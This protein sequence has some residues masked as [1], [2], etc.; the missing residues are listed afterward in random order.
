MYLFLKEINLSRR[1]S[2]FGGIVFAFSG[3]MIVWWEENFMSSY[4]AL[5]LPLILYSIEKLFKR[6]SF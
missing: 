4:S 2:L 6:I 1:S 5:F 3:F